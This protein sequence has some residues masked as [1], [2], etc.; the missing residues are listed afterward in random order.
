MQKIYVDAEMLFY[1]FRYSL[2]RRSYA[3]SW[4]VDNIL[5]NIKELPHD[6]L[7]RFITEIEESYDL[8]M[9]MDKREWANLREKLIKELNQK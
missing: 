4:V 9:N 7:Q 8:G 1:A 5:A 2:G 3:P 6:M